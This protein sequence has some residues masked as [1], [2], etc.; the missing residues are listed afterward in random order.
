MNRDR[1][2]KIRYATLFKDRFYTKK[3][4]ERLIGLDLKSEYHKVIAHTSKLPRRMRDM[5]KYAYPKLRDAEKLE[6][7]AAINKN[8]FTRFMAWLKNLFARKKKHDTESQDSTLQ[9]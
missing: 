6:E 3:E 7:L 8:I 4:L 9:L 5:V 1:N 2:K